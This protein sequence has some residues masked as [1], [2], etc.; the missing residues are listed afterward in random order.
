MPPPSGWRTRRRSSCRA[1]SPSGAA[2]PPAR[3]CAGCWWPVGWL[4]WGGDGVMGALGIVTWLAPIVYL[5][6]LLPLLRASAT[7]AAPAS[8]AERVRFAPVLRLGGTAWLTNLISGALLKQTAVSLLQYFLIG[9]GTIGYFHLAFQLS[10]AAAFLLIAGLG[11]VGMAAMSAAFVAARHD[12]LTLAWRSVSKAQILLAVPVLAF[13]FVNAN[14]IAVLLYT[15][16]NA[17]VGPL[18]PIFLVFNIAQR[19]PGGGSHP[20]AAYLLRRP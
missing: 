10:H 17:A 6:L 7:G 20:P 1:P 11:G 8:S 16:A 15:P 4:R 3:C 14:T 2:P 19:L 9:V 13:F 12:G 5:V 18:T